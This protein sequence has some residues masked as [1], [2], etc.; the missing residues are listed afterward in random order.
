M[1][2]K[3]SLALPLLLLLFQATDA[4]AQQV[5][6]T[7]TLAAENQAISAVQFPDIS[8]ATFDK[9]LTGQVQYYVG[10]LNQTAG[11][12]RTTIRYRTGGAWHSGEIIFAKNATCTEAAQPVGIV[13][14]IACA[15]VEH[16]AGFVCSAVYTK[17][18]NPV[19]PKCTGTYAC[20]RCGNVKV[21]GSNPQC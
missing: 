6:V 21:C 9:P 2:W 12:Y 14:R 1:R 4:N 15:V 5:P 18:A 16:G 7:V 17:M 11:E 10:M 20:T 19:K 8:P 3:L 13:E